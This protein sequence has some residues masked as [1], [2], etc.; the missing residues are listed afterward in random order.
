MKDS[1]EKSLKVIHESIFDKIKR[2]ISGIMKKEEKN[3]AELTN[4]YE[5][6]IET[7]PKEEEL[8]NEKTQETI[9]LIKRI[10]KEEINLEEKDNTELEQI[11]E[12]LT[13]YLNKIQKEINST[14][15]EKK[16]VENQIKNY[17]EQMAKYKDRRAN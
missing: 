2:F 5:I 10:E 6:E 11:N 1:N 14:K 4:S 3:V 8:T 16:I 15:S 13:R 12:N 17:Q 9:K 7:E